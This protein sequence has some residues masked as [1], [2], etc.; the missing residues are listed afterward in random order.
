MDTTIFHDFCLF[1][2][3]CLVRPL[4]RLLFLDPG[5]EVVQN[6]LAEL[7]SVENHPDQMDQWM[8]LS[9]EHIFPFVGRFGILALPVRFCLNLA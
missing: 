1:L 7:C 9:W 2:F 5:P 3:R 8:L 6:L 4:V